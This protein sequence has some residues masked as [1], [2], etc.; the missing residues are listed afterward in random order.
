[1]NAWA[2]GDGPVPYRLTVSAEA[3]LAAE[4]TLSANAS[5]PYELTPAAEAALDQ[6]ELEAS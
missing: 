6:P 3:R 1:V 4:E 5:T 2:G